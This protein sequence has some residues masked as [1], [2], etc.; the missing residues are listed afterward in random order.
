MENVSKAFHGKNI[1]NNVS[2][3][4]EQKEIFGL[5][6]LV[7]FVLPLLYIA[8]SM[9]MDINEIKFS[10][11]SFITFQL[12]LNPVLC[13]ATIIAEEKEKST[14]NALITAGVKPIEYLLGIGIFVILNAVLSI[15]IYLFRYHIEVGQIFYFY[16]ITILGAICSTIIGGIVGL[17]AKRQSSVGPICTIISMILGVSTMMSNFSDKLYKVTSFFYAQQ[18]SNMYGN[19][20]CIFKI[21]KISIVI[22]DIIILFAI[23]SVAYKKNKFCE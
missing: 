18:I 21:D 15:S 13:M 16:F 3:N 8:L 6:V 4:I 14:L 23:F 17:S 12:I 22:I 1:I 11:P 2:I 5:F 7:F 19:N 9:H 10:T 20:Q